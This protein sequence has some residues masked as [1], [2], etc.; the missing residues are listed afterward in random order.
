MSV[1]FSLNPLIR[2]Q[3]NELSRFFLFFVFTGNSFCTPSW[4]PTQCSLTGHNKQAGEVG[5]QTIAP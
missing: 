1:R 5:V 2:L 4:K 3:L